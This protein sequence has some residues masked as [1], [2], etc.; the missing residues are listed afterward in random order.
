MPRRSPI[1][2]GDS[3][4]LIRRAASVL[5]AIAR[6]GVDGIRLVDIARITGI[7]RPSVH[8]MLQHLLEI[9]Y[10]ERHSDKLYAIGPGLFTLGLAAPNPIQNP[11]LLRSLAVELAERTG[12]TVYV[13]MRHIDGVHYL[14]R[15][16]GQFPIRTHF[17]GLGDVR[18]YTSTYSGIA[19]LAHLSETERTRALE[20]LE[21]NAAAE[22]FASVDPEAL[23]PILMQKI[24]DVRNEGYFWGA[25]VVR[26]GVTGMAAVVPS[27]TATP[28]VAVSISTIESRLPASRVPPVSALLLDTV[29]R[30]S[31]AIL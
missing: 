11:I 8:R 16:E 27:L 10:V 13:S 4:Q 2:S 3:V 6:E 9:N 18:A 25:D 28:Y 23:R 1:E 30:M 21:L 5:A 15:E 22:S 31:H 17:I 29:N 20:Q 24:N 14:M 7:A 26:S 12:D 19:L